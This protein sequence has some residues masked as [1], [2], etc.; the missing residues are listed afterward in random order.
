MLKKRKVPTQKK[1]M[2]KIIYNW[3][4]DGVLLLAQSTSFLLNDMSTNRGGGLVSKL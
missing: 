3:P 4:R 2:G 1:R